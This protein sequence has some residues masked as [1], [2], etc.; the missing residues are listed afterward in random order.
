MKDIGA[1]RQKLK[2]VLYR[3]R[4]KHIQDRLSV[5]PGNCK[6]NLELQGL[7][8]GPVFICGG[9]CQGVVC[10][11]NHN[12]PS[13]NCGFFEP[14]WEVDEI[15]VTFD[16]ELSEKSV[17]EVAREYP[18]AAALMWVLEEEETDV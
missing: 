14:A 15:K 16:Q 18:D 17:A 4:K 3:H 2:Q 11:I 7:P 12:N 8:M 6:H 10:D 1:I 13:E 9:T 5:E